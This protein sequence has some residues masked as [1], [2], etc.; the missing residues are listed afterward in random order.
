MESWKQIYNHNRTSTYYTSFQNYY[1]HG[2]T[3]LMGL[4]GISRESNPHP[5]Q[6]PGGFW[7]PPEEETTPS[8][9]QSV[10]VPC[11]PEEYSD[12]QF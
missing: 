3:E 6:V 1:Q 2:I 11:H 7:K 9:W 5:E 8:L 10:P 12:E 4:E